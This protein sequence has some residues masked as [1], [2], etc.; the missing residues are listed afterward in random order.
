MR[1][2]DETTASHLHVVL[3]K[4]GYHFTFKNYFAVQN[5]VRLDI[6]QQ[7]VLPSYLFRK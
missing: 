5:P 1:K 2:D 3:T 7:C 4:L 6:L